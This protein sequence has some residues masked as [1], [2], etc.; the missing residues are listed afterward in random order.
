VEPT[1]GVQSVGS[2]SLGSPEILRELGTD[3]RL[4]ILEGL[5][6]VEV[7]CEVRVPVAFVGDQSRMRPLPGLDEF[8]QPREE[9]CLVE[10]R[11][12]RA[13]AGSHGFRR[14]NRFFPFLNLTLLGDGEFL[15]PP[16]TLRRELFTLAG[17]Q[18]GLLNSE[19]SSVGFQFLKRLTSL[20]GYAR[21]SLQV[22][23]AIRF[24]DD[25]L[26]LPSMRPVL[27]EL[28]IQVKENRERDIENTGT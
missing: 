10:L 15:N 4:V 25:H 3:V 17:K 23:S 20:E 22:V 27:Q 2:V 1:D 7:V 18:N 19:G 28:K 11:Y 5:R 26:P 14:L 8:F 24:D 6:S 16:V 9:D 21:V 12:R 13:F